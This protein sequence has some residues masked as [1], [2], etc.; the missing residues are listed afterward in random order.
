MEIEVENG[1]KTK[2]S[3]MQPCRASGAAFDVKAAP[4]PGFATDMQAQ[5]RHYYTAKGER[6]DRDDLR[7]QN[8]ACC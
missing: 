4:H 6:C 2:E 7:K 8:D 1:E 3:S 5:Q